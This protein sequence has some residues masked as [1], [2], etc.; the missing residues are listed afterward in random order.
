MRTI[1]KSK[2]YDSSAVVQVIG[3]I[4]NNPN[5]LESNGKYFYGEQDFVN[6]FHRVVFGAA[7]NLFTMGTNNITTNDIENYLENRPESKNIYK[8]GRGAT[9]I[10]EAKQNAELANFDYYYSRMKKMTLMRGYEA[11]GMNMRWLY[12]PDEIFDEK[13][14]KAQEDYLDSLSLQEIADLI[15]CKVENVKAEFIDNATDEA[16]LI[17]ETVFDILEGLKEKPEIGMTLYGDYVNNLHRGARL[18]KFYLR[19]APSGV[20]KTRTMI[21]DACTVGADEIYDPNKKEWV[22]TYDAQPVLYIST[23]LDTEEVTTMCLAF[24][25]GVNENHI[26]MNEYEFGEYDRVLYAARLLQRS[27]IYIEEMPDFSI[28]SVENVIKRSIRTKGVQYCFFDYL[29]SSLGILREISRASGGTKLREDNIL[30]LFSV[31]LKDIAN[32]FNIFILSSTQLNMTWKTD[33]IPDQNLLRGSKAIAD[34][35]DW[36]SILLDVTQEDREALENLIPQTP[37]QIM[38]N[39]KLSVYKNRRG[40]YNKMYLW[41]YADKGTCRFDGLFATD[42]D[43]NPIKLKKS[44]EAGGE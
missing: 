43:Y 3:S 38:P 27:P 37:H 30:F 35:V 31:A 34:R 22:K 44:I 14:K 13:K 5:L 42:Y 20:G 1:K 15:D 16:A 41:M 33:D 23:E 2:Y 17:G 9:W 21:A 12:D 10:A 26:L 8:A 18:G 4:L 40:S 19:S 6:N 11:C 29:H 39:V 36:G 32:N 24:L 28:K 25:S 7:Y